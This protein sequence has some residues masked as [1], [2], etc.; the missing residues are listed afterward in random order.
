M[1]KEPLT[2]S[3]LCWVLVKLSGAVLLYQGLAGL[4]AGAITWVSL[5][6]TA[7]SL[8]PKLRG[9]VMAPVSVLFWSVLL[10]LIIGIRLL[11]SG[12]TLHGWLM[13]VPF[14]SGLDSGKGKPVGGESLAEQRL[15]VE[16]YE[17][18]RTW[19]DGNDEVARRD[20]FD[21]LALFRDAQKR[22]E[23]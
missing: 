22:G 15:T 16:E 8:P 7:E 5:H 2:K 12:R 11:M 10:P 18:Y 6:E 4:F 23:V 1:E 20:E 9:Q 19:L 13:M 3:D 21:Q 17:K 14:L